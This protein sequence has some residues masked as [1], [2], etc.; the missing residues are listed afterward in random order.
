VLIALGVIV[1]VLVQRSRSGERVIRTTAVS[2]LYE[3]VT[4]VLP[5]TSVAPKLQ[6]TVYDSGSGIPIGDLA[7]SGARADVWWLPARRGGPFLLVAWHRPDERRERQ[8][9]NS[10]TRGVILWHRRPNTWHLVYARRHPWW[11]HLWLDRGDVTGDGRT[12]VLLSEENGGSGGCGVRRVL[13]PL[14]G[15]ASEVFR[16]HLCEAQVALEGGAVIVNEA[17]GPCPYPEGRAHCFGGRKTSELRWSGA[18]L[19]PVR[20]TIECALPRL[21]PARSC[22]RRTTR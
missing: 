4:R 21:D 11:I 6:R 13:A 15:R 1:G 18:A 2:A 3:T 8:E 19:R 10:R 17:I 14:P 22:E 7:P 12:D 20:V 16:R 9:K 5:Q